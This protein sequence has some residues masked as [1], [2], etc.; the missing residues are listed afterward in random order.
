MR[1]TPAIATIVARL[2][3]SIVLAALLAGCQS[4]GPA[5]VP[6]VKLTD[7]DVEMILD[8][9]V[10]AG[11]LNNTVAQMLLQQAPALIERVVNA[12]R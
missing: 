1:R 8:Q 10:A 9:A 6:K 4:S 5:P 11:K 7:A 3:V 12:H 2:T